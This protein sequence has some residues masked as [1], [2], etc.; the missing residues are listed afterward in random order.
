[1]KTDLISF[2]LIKNEK[3]EIMKVYKV[4]SYFVLIFLLCFFQGTAFTQGR[5]DNK[6]YQPEQGQEGKDVRWFPTPQSLVDKMLDMA[7]ITKND[8]LV[9]LGSGDGRTVI[10]AAKR[11]VR[12]IGIEYN[13]DLVEL[14]KRNATTEGV[15]DKAEFI[16][17]DFFDF[18]FSKATVITMF[19]LPE[20][21]LRLRPKLLRMKPGTR[22]VST[23]FTM[24]DWQY[25]DMVTVD[26]K[27]SKWTTAYLWIVPA[28]IAG[29]WKFNNGEL[30]L[31]QKYQMVSGEI[32]RGGKA[33]R[34]TGGR[35]RGN[36]LTF[37]ADGTSYNCTLSGNTLKGRKEDWIAQMQN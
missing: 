25:D 3:F 30:K 32:T 7:G 22:V 20:I 16:K 18:D 1:L 13:P 24:Q 34:I 10:S 23:T 6:G 4:R 33:F 12:G 29:T 17:A 8:F 9:D 15:A 36:D 21:N 35:L 27:S 37:K 14:S 31:T 26:D 2:L 11:G 19:L 28:K 5:V